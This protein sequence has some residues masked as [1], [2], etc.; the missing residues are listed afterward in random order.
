LTGAQCT[1]GQ[2]CDYPAGAQCG[3]ADQTGV[4]K[5]RPAGCTKEYR[6]VCGCDDRT[7]GNA[8]VANAAGVSVRAQGECQSQQIVNT[9]EYDDFSYELGANFLSRDGCNSCMCMGGG[10]VSCGVQCPCRYDDPAIDWISRDARE[11]TLLDFQCP[12]DT[13]QF[14]NRCGCGCFTRD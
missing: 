1:S 9:C 3:A 11:C 10:H 13:R 14:T 7:Y 8:C 12:A 5:A 2:L 4:C 6:P